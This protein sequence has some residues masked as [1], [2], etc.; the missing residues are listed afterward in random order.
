M[1]VRIVTDST[2]DLPSQL[3]DKYRIIVVPL[4]VS[5]GDEAFLDGVTIDRAA[6]YGRMR[7]FDGL[8]KTSQPTVGQF[9]EAYGPLAAD[10]AEV[11]SIHL[12]SKMSGTLNSATLAAKDMEG[13]KLELIDSAQVSMGLAAVVLAAAEAA[14]A[15]GSSAE[16]AAAARETAARTHIYA[17]VDTLEYLRRGGRIGRASS[18]L[19]SLLSIK[20]IIHIADG[21]IQPLERV[22]TRGKAIE[23]LVE[24]ATA[25]PDLPRLFVAAAGDDASAEALAARLRPLL[26][27]TEIIVG[28]LGPVVGAHAGPGLLGICTVARA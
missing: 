25:D 6:F 12:S 1:P 24:L 4:T 22:R 2:A 18:L 21:E 16:V 7:T 15:G 28:Q 26:P 5:F 14:A 8:P 9:R 11:V 13:V 23:R 10:G 20:P 19:G 17:A 27:R 3:V